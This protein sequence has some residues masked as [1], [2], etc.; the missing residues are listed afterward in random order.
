MMQVAS[1]FH[2]CAAHRLPDHPGPCRNLHG[3]NYRLVVR[4]EGPVDA[5]TGM[6]IDFFTLRKTVEELVLARLDHADLNTLLQTPT[7]ENIAVWIWGALAPH[8]STLAEIT[9]YETHDSWV[10]YRPGR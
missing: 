2:F 10:S 4:C 9:L 3:H 7:A 8:L 1:E 5:P 6:V